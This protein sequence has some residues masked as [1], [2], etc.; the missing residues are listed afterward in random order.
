MDGSEA[1]T[2]AY[3]RF[4]ERTE[5]MTLREAISNLRSPDFAAAM[6]LMVSVLRSPRGA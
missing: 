2:E 3:P 6:E 1:I 5:P 4:R